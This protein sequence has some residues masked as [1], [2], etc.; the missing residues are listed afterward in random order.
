MKTSG[1]GGLFY[2]SFAG[3]QT[4]IFSQHSCMVDWFPS[5]AVMKDHGLGEL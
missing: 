2:L 1:L 5:V 3:L 4:H